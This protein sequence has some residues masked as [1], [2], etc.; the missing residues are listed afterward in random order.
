LLAII[1]GLVLSG[2]VRVA[3]TAGYWHTSQEGESTAKQA[4]FDTAGLVPG[5]ASPGKIT[6]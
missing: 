2:C 6:A 4:G 3:G 5:N 1:A